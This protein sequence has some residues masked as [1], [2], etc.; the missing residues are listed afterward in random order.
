EVTNPGVLSNDY[1]I[2]GDSLLAELLEGPAHGQLQFNADGSF[3][4]TPD[5]GFS[6]DDMFRYLVVDAAGATHVG[7]VMLNVSSPPPP[8][9]Q[10]IDTEPG[11]E[12]VTELPDDENPPSEDPV[13]EDPVAEDPV[14]V[15]EVPVIEDP[16]DEAPVLDEP[17]TEDPLAPPPPPMDEGPVN[18]PVV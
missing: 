6:G 11:D 15:I 3:V 9:T 7:Q 4:Y 14:P 16:V 1:D 10:P 13:A 12:P 5:E 8:V 2:D 17:V 18:D